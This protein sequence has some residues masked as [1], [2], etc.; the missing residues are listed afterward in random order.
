MKK[1]VFLTLSLIM[2]VAACTQP[3]NKEQLKFGIKIGAAFSNYKIKYADP[4]V[5]ASTEAKMSYILGVLVY[6]PIGNNISFSPGLELVRKGANETTVSQ[7]YRYSAENGY[8]CL[9]APLNIVYE[10]K[11]KTGKF[12]LGGGPVISYI[13][14]E[15][16]FQNQLT[17]FD[18]GANMLLSYEWPIG[19]SVNVNFTQGLK[20]VSAEKTI[21]SNLKNNYFGLSAGYMF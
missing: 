21:I 12:R 13:F 19:F 18:L 9:D 16:Y 10:I 8:T 17:S 6:L 15:E 5:K 7:G 3:S 4:D 11:N 20:N 1:T 2:V 14:N